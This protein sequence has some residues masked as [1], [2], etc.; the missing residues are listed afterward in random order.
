MKGLLKR[1]T[2]EGVRAAGRSEGCRVCQG[3]SEA[4]TAGFMNS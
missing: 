2:W 4:E 1:G 3:G